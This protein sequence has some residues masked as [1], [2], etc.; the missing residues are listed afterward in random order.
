MLTKVNI[1][2]KLATFNDT[3][4]PRIVGEVNDFHV[5]VVKLKGAFEWHHHDHEDELFLVVK[6]WLV[7]GLKD[8]EDITVNEGEFIIIPHGVVHR[9]LAEE[10]C[11]IVLFE[12]GT[13]L[14]TGNI[15]SD[16]TVDKLERI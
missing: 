1:T 13:T 7:M 14:N 9:P 8:Q 11:H 4:H 10:E 3:W 12:P 5:K 16:R 2:Q 6:G 15:Q